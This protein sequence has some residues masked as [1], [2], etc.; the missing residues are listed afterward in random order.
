MTNEYPASVILFL[1]CKIPVAV[2]P[3]DKKEE[4]VSSELVCIVKKDV[5]QDTSPHL[6]AYKC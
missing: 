4:K 1:Q 5:D 3:S 2:R 6:A